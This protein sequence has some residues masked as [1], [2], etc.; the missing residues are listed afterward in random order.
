[1]KAIYTLFTL[2]CCILIFSQKTVANHAMA[3]DLTYACLNEDEQS[4]NI[5]LDFYFDCGSVIIQAPAASVVVNVFSN[6]CGQALQVELTRDTSIEGEEVSQLCDDILE[7]GQSNCESGTF[8][9]VRKY[10]FEGTVTLPKK[11]NDWTFSYR[12]TELEFRSAT[13]TNL[14]SPELQKIYVQATLDN[15]EGCNS[16][17]SFASIP[18]AYYCTQ[19]STFTQGIIE[20]DGDELQFTLIQPLNNFNAPIAYTNNATPQNPFI[21]NSFNFDNQTGEIQFETDLAQFP[22]VAVLVEEYRNGRLVGS[23]IRDMQFVVLDCENQ[24]VEAVTLPQLPDGQNGFSICAGQNANLEFDFEFADADTEDEISITARNIADFNGASFSQVPNTLNPA[25]ANFE[26]FP[27]L[28]D[29]GLHILEVEVSDNRCPISSRLIYTYTIEVV[30]EPNA[31]PDLSFCE[32]GGPL[33]VE[34]EGGGQFTWT[35]SEHLTFLNTE[36]SLVEIRPDNLSEGTELTYTITNSCNLSDELK[37]TVVQDIL[38]DFSEDV[39]ICQGDIA[40]MFALPIVGEPSFYTYAW[41]P[42]DEVDNPTA[43]AVIANP[44]ENSTYSVSVRSNES[45]CTVHHDFNIGV[46][47]FTGEVNV[48]AA[49]TDLCLGESTQ[50]NAIGVFNAILNCGV[51]SNLQDCGSEAI[52]YELGE[53]EGSDV[54]YTPYHGDKKG[55]RLQILYLQED[56]AAIGMQSGFINSIAFNVTNLLSNGNLTYHELSIKMGCTDVEVINDFQLGLQEVYFANEYNTMEDWNV[57]EFFRPYKWDGTS[58]LIVEICYNDATVSSGNALFD[59]VAYTTVDY[60]CVFRA[61]SSSGGGCN[62]GIGPNINNGF[63]RPDIQF[64]ICPPQPETPPKISWMPSESLD[65]PKVANPIAMPTE[66]TT[67]TVTFDDQGCTGSAEITINVPSITDF[68][69]RPD[70]SICEAGTVPL[71]IEGNFPNSATFE[72]S[73]TEG[74]NSSTIPNPTATVTENTTYQVIVSL[75]DDCNT[76]ITETVNITIGGL[77]DAAI[78]EEESICGGETADLSASGGTTYQWSPV[79]TLSCSDCPNPTANPT[80]STVYQVVVTN[81]TGCSA[82]LTTAIEVSGLENAS[83]SE[84]GT[85][86]QNESLSLSATGGTTYEWSPSADLSCKDC[87]NPKANPLTTTTYQVVITDDSDCST[88]LETTIEVN[89]VPTIDFITPNQTA[90]KGEELQ[91]E[92]TGDFSSVRWSS[93]ANVVDFSISNPVLLVTETI[94]YVVEV[95]NDNGC[96]ASAI[97]SIGAL[98]APER[99]PCTGIVVP[100]AFSPNEDGVNDRFFPHPGSFDELL[101]FKI[102]NRWGKEVFSTSTAADGWDGISKNE[103]QDMGTYAYFVEAV[104]EGETLRKQGWVMLIR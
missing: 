26:W 13:I 18:V 68:A 27:T 5:T 102:Y 24:S 4:Y 97:V 50:L 52:L 81:D 74:L 16:A 76:Q 85:I 60:A 95:T 54:T 58:N 55:N 62:L 71:Y 17:P 28:A 10:I 47:P 11:C 12:L 38:L 31:G 83:I 73:P 87:P 75:N 1:M 67:Y 25:T 84:G 40:T 37:V 77:G 94:T 42:A 22:V 66:T 34:I 64:N 49:T 15:T 48:S 21:T 36:N 35:P 9:G 8:A 79:E 92:V 82:I 96:T 69:L 103:V 43:A 78:S 101:Q 20:T 2:L 32:S 6:S 44:T 51:E 100:T 93:G 72:W 99:E 33:R 98:D 86:C 46:S 19:N 65:D 63:K 53:A 91:L 29:A 41:S 57:H 104:C 70:T 30:G 88:T 23:V 7:N 56:L 3:I 89:E 39:T 45:G 90:V 61:F 80:N 14:V 59:Q